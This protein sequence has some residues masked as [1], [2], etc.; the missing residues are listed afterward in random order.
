MQL[1]PYLIFNGNCEAA[2][3][4]YQQHLGGKID[5][6]HR[7]SDSPMADQCGPN[8]GEKIMHVSMSLDGKTL[9]ASDAGPNQPYEGMKGFSLSLNV[10]DVAEA[11]KIFAALSPNATIQMPLQPTFWAARFGMLTDQFGTP[12]MVN[13]ELAPA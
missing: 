13:C 5:A 11:E 2:F 8:L 12:W 4:F 9:M 6:M 3:L 10:K 1:N 7:F